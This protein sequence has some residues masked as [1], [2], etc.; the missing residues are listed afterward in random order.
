MTLLTFSIPL[1][2]PNAMITNVTAN[3]SICQL[4][5]PNGTAIFPKKIPMS[6]TFVRF[7]VRELHRYFMTH[8]TTTEYPIAIPRE[9]IT[10]IT[11][12]A[13]PIGR[14]FSPNRISI[15]FP[16]EPS[17]PVFM[18]RPNAISPITPENPS[19][20][21]NIKYGIKNAAPPNLPVLYG[22]IQI[23]AIPTVE[24]IHAITNP[25]FVRNSSLPF[26]TVLLISF[27]PS[28]IVFSTKE[29][30]SKCLFPD[31]RIS[32]IIPTALPYSEA[33]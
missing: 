16:K 32:L 20:T 12:I 24:P 30:Y 22:N 5:F 11:P 23:L 3:P 26:S 14:P 25:I 2:I 13:L 10:G 6:S 7:P 28:T 15:A 33:T 21:T 8:P 17:G 31:I 18:L 19:S 29:A 4:I 1:V 27:S 9:P